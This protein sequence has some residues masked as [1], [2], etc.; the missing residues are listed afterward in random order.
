MVLVDREIAEKVTKEELIESYDERCLTNIGY[1][2]RAKKFYIAGQGEDFV[3]LNPMESAFVESVEIVNMPK[4]ILGRVHLKNSRIRQGLSLESPV[5]QPG[6]KTRIYFR[7]TNVSA[8]KIT[9]YQDERYGTI[10]FEQLSS[11]PDHLYDGGFCDEFSFKGLADYADAYKKQVREIEKQTEDLK[12]VERNI[13]GNVLVILSVFVALFTLLTTDMSLLKIGATIKEYFLFDSL[14]LGCISFL[15]GL[16]ET[17][18]KPSGKRKYAWIPAI[19]C[20]IAA[21]LICIFL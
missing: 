13:Y 11:V 9:L 6:H 10:V 3:T 15:V 8:D 12:S 21:L 20:F 4:D 1:D 14:I 2:L 17:V 16:I 7:L 5:Y 19:V 18:I